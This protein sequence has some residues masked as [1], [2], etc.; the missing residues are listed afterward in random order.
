M[1]PYSYSGDYRECFHTVGG[2]S[3][4]DF[5]SRVSNR[6]DEPT[7]P[8]KPSIHHELRIE[9]PENK[10]PKRGEPEEGA[11]DQQ[12]EKPDLDNRENINRGCVLHI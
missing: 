7:H 5:F 8:V 4:S 6:G 1:V 2:T 10:L 11:K 3:A 9:N 12:S